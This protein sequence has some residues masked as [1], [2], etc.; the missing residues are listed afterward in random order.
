M[1]GTVAMNVLDAAYARETLQ[2]PT[3]GPRT[4]PGRRPI[5]LDRASK[6]RAVEA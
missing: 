2:R 6:V 4:L 5:P 1:A 3:D